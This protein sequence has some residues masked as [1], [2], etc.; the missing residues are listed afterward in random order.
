MKNHIILSSNNRLSDSSLTEPRWEV[1][2]NVMSSGNLTVEQFNATRYPNTDWVLMDHIPA[3]SGSTNWFGRNDALGFTGVSQTAIG[4]ESDLSQ[5]FRRS[6]TFESNC[7]GYNEIK[8]Q[9]VNT[10]F[11]NTTN[12]AYW[13]FSKETR[14]KFAI[15]SQAG[16]NGTLTVG[17]ANSFLFNKFPLIDSWDFDTSDQAKSF[18]VDPNFVTGQPASGPFIVSHQHVEGNI[19]CFYLEN[20]NGGTSGV[21][22]SVGNLLQYAMQIWIRR[23][24]PRYNPYQIISSQ[25]SRNDYLSINTKTTPPVGFMYFQLF[26]PKTIASSMSITEIRLL[27]TSGTNALQSSSYISSSDDANSLAVETNPSS[28]EIKSGDTLVDIIDNSILSNARVGNIADD[29]DEVIQFKLNREYTFDEFNRLE[30]YFNDENGPF[31]IRFLNANYELIHTSVFYTSKPT[32]SGT[33]ESVVVLKFLGPNPMTGFTNHLGNEFAVNDD[34]VTYVYDWADE[35]VL[36]DSYI[37]RKVLEIPF[38]LGIGGVPEQIPHF[39]KTYNQGRTSGTTFGL[40]PSIAKITNNTLSMI[41]PSLETSNSWFHAGHIHR[42]ATNNDDDFV[43]SPYNNSSQTTNWFSQDNEMTFRISEG[44]PSSTPNRWIKS[45]V[46]TPYEDWNEIMIV[47]GENSGGQNWYWKFRRDARISKA[48]SSTKTGQKLAIPPTGTKTGQKWEPYEYFDNNWETANNGRIFLDNVRTFFMFTWQTDIDNTGN[49]YTPAVMFSQRDNSFP[50]AYSNSG[51]NF[52]LNIYYEVNASW[53]DAMFALK[54]GDPDNNY[55]YNSSNPDL[56]F[57]GL[58]SLDYYVRNN[59]EAVKSSYEPKK[60]LFGAKFQNDG[61]IGFK[62]RNADGSVPNEEDI[63]KS[64][65]LKVKLCDC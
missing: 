30:I 65:S 52:A 59:K 21:A 7:P 9:T 22:N 62:F 31:Q 55:R 32:F 54:G 4:A 47:A 40:N 33:D 18:Y 41:T 61:Q 12:R 45:V 1:N 49:S 19:Q 23:Y 43:F 56:R 58:I 38:N 35:L 3:Q 25:F 15:Q 27:E 53:Y 14:D 20:N 34:I 2:D 51:N 6:G 8:I 50:A 11:E 39:Q 36:S 44:S 13:I 28:S 60:P 42:S 17:G 37:Y 63:P 29:E 46:N 57:S 26:V 10:N 48:A 5:N 64:Y 24:V 16:E